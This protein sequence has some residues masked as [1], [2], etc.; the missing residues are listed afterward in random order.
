MGYTDEEILREALLRSKNVLRRRRERTTRVLAGAS[1]A[2]LTGL[3][4]LIALMP[5]Q[6]TGT[7]SQSSLYGSLM[8]GRE[9]GGYVL[10]AV[11]AFL[12]GVSVTVLCGR[13]RDHTP[14]GQ[15]T[16]S[17]PQTAQHE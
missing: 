3:I 12:L 14:T 15:G 7:Y 17:P 6:L 11:I 9:A 10:V 8:L 2:L 16:D 5:A 1:A 13:L 4:V